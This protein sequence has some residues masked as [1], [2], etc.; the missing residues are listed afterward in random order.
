MYSYKNLVD[1]HRGGLRNSCL[2][3]PPHT[4]SAG[5]GLIESI[6]AKLPIS[7]YRTI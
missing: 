2:L 3:Y 1:A 5:D 7:F 4:S 6:I